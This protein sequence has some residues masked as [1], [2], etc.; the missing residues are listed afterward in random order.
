M[1]Q[2]AKNIKG[3]NI[4]ELLV[5]IAIV[6][7]ISAAAYP[8]FNSWR[9]DRAT[10]SSALDIKNLL[11]NI[12]AQVQRGSYGFVQVQLTELA[13]TVTATSR[14]M[15]NDKLLSKIRSTNSNWWNAGE[16]NLR[17]KMDTDPDFEIDSDG[18]GSY[19]THDGSVNTDEDPA[20]DLVQVNVREFENIALD[21]REESGAIC[22][23]TDGTWYQGNGALIEGGETSNVLYVCTRSGAVNRCAIAATGRPTGEYEALFEISWSRFGNVEMQKW[24]N[25]QKKWVLQ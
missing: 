25:R 7:V 3:F 9:K 16:E 10:R 12:N 11:Q 23:S 2:Q 19:W 15:T 14:G 21:F 6:A 17:C 1:H 8:N 22:F 5:V 13:G 18:G 24:N 4:L 20:N